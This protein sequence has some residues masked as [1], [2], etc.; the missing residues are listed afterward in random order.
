MAREISFRRLPWQSGQITRASLSARSSFRSKSISASVL[1]LKESR[2]DFLERC[3]LGT[4]SPRPLQVLHHPRGELNEKWAGS[5]ASKER[6][7]TGLTRAFEK[8]CRKLPESRIR[9][10]PF[11][12]WRAVATASRTAEIRVLV[13]E[14]CRMRTSISCSWKRSS[15]SNVSTSFPVSYTHLTLPTK[16]IV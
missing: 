15:R 2:L 14:T 9:R 11:P 3:W 12:N 1:E 7:V 10:V 16:R 4:T 13:F 5:G 8:G 6:P